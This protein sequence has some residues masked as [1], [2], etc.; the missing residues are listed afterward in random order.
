MGDKPKTDETPKAAETKA[1][2]LEGPAG[3]EWRGGPVSRSAGCSGSGGDA[4]LPHKPLPTVRTVDFALVAHVQE[5]ARVAQGGAFAF[6][7]DLGFTDFDDFDRFHRWCCLHM[8][9]WM[10]RVADH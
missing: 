8:L 9:S 7:G 10:A 5:Y 1:A 6:A 2:P 3:V 4:R